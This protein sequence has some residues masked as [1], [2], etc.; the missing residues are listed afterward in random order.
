MRFMGYAVAIALAAMV[1]GC[2]F[3]K[4]AINLTPRIDIAESAIGGGKLTMVSVADERPRTTLGTRGVSGIGEQLTINGDLTTIVRGA[5]TDGL[6]RQ[7][8]ATEGPLENQLRVEIRNLDYA[9][10]SGFWAGKLNVEFLLKGIC[11]KGSNRPYE[12]MYRGEFRKSIQV[13]QGEDS[14]NQ[15]VNAVVSDAI[16]SLLRDQQMMSCL[17]QA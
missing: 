3:Q 10:N 1:S 15:F 16:N 5:I 2:A 9:I 17:A 7:G 8:F 13:V 14:N 12:Q 4:Q 11:V 6:K